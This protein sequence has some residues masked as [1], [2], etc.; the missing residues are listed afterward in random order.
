MLSLHCSKL[1]YFIQM[2]SQ[3]LLKKLSTWFRTPSP[4]LLFSEFSTSFPN[5]GVTLI[6]TVVPWFVLS[7]IIQCVC[8]KGHFHCQLFAYFCLSLVPGLVFVL[9]GW[10]WGSLLP[11]EFPNLHK[12]NNYLA[13]SLLSYLVNTD[14]MEIV[15]K[16]GQNMEEKYGIGLFN[17][18]YRAMTD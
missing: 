3:G 4:D 17:Q 13:F 8:W 7:G 5:W 1:E 11:D 2:F 9:P 18:Q 14:A 15:G 16:N 10:N 6:S 12:P